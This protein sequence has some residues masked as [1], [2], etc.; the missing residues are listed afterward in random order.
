MNK[1]DL[2][3][4]E[5]EALIKIFEEIKEILVLFQKLHQKIM[6]QQDK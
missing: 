1:E 2:S 5:I 4:E 3:K 6:E